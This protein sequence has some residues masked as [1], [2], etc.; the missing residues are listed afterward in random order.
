MHQ[1]FDT[2]KIQER[3]PIFCFQEAG[4]PNGKMHSRAKKKNPEENSVSIV[5]NTSPYNP[6]HSQI[7]GSYWS[8]LLKKKLESSKILL[9]ICQMQL[10]MDTVCITGK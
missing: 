2:P 4:L 7:H 1:A 3:A 9:Q 10:C 6:F 8:N 5:G